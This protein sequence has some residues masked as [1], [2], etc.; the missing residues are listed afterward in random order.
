MKKVN[1]K[2]NCSVSFL[3]F[4]FLIIFSTNH[5]NAGCQ[6]GSETF[7][8]IDGTSGKDGEITL[9]KIKKWAPGDDVTTCDVSKLTSL[10]RAFVDK[11]SFN[12]EIG[13]W[14]TSNV[15]DMSYMFYGASAFNQEIGS[16][17]TS[18]VMD[19][20]HIFDNAPAFN[21]EIGSWDTSNVMDMSRMFTRASAF[22]QEI[23]S[24]DTSNVTD[25]S[26]MFYGASA[27]NQDIRGWAISNENL[28]LTLMFAG[29]TAMISTYA[30]EAGFGQ[31]P[32]LFFFNHSNINPN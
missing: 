16:W 20:S 28:S 29:A 31:T 23:G 2:L 15:T 8:S 13:S 24:W 14:D 26:Y 12:Q 9:N 22:N 10:T 21:Q 4:I 7:N 18:N 27:F 25:M 11:S 6:V 32:K 17:D 3:T 30:G 1:N 19:M 5:T